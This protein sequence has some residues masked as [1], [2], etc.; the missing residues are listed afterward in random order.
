M[1]HPMDEEGW[2]SMALWA[3]AASSQ[4]PNIF[5]TLCWQAF[6]VSR[7]GCVGLY[8]TPGGGG[9]TE[10][11]LEQLDSV[12]AEVKVA[13]RMPGCI[14]VKVAKQWL[15]MRGPRGCKAASALGA[16][17]KVRNTRAHPKCK[18]LVEEI[19][20]LGDATMFE[21]ESDVTTSTA[22]DS[23]METPAKRDAEH[24]ARPPGQPF[25]SGSQDELKQT[26]K[27]HQ[28]HSG[29]ILGVLEDMKERA[30][31][32]LSDPCKAEE[33]NQHNF[34]MLK[35]AHEDQMA[36]ESQDMEDEHQQAGE[37]KEDENKHATQD[38]AECIEVIPKMVAETEVNIANLAV[39]YRK[40]KGLPTDYGDDDNLGPA[41]SIGHL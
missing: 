24:S 25:I 3:A 33:S 19:K 22:T 4:S 35:Y 31:G 37:L 8:Q 27:S 21:Q 38:L 40:A 26:D 9:A 12:L 23:A 5:R 2:L 36:A 10:D 30:E 18:Q 11:P 28:T 15:R 20:L 13:S 16:L 1:S 17:T 7:H 14:D 34:D 6:E 32:Q 29:G 41:T 39:A